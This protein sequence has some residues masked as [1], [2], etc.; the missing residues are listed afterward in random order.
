MLHARGADLRLEKIDIYCLDHQSAARGHGIAGAACN[1][2]NGVFGLPFFETGVPNGIIGTGLDIESIT[3]RQDEHWFHITNNGIEA[4]RL[5]FDGLGPGKGREAIREFLHPL[6]TSQRPS[7]GRSGSIAD[8][9]NLS[10]DRL[11]MTVQ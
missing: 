11:S 8:V 4:D 9:A 7:N 3:K 5:Q 1:V 2:E 10:D 6:Y